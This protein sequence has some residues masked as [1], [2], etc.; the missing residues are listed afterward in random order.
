MDLKIEGHENDTYTTEAKTFEG[1]KLV[2]SP[3]NAKGKMKVTVNEDGTFSSKT[4]VKYY[5]VHLSA[6]VDEKHIDEMSGN[7]LAQTHYDGK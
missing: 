7:V 1:Y 3:E 2:E 5:Y 6:G 4:I